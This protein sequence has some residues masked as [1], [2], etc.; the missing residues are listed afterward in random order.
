MNG[1]AARAILAGVL[2]TL[3]FAVVQL[4]RNGV[5]WG[6]LAGVAAAVGMF[7][8]AYWGAERLGDLRQAA[9]EKYWAR[10]EGRHHQFAGVRLRVEEQGQ[11]TWI[12]ADGLT[13]ALGHLDG[14]P[15]ADT[16]AVV[17]ARHAGQWRR[18]EDGTLMLR[19]DAVV[20]R[21]SLMP[22]R[23]DPRVQRLRRYLERDVLFPARR[24][25]G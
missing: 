16:E 10:H 6:L 2:L 12:D 18:A 9:R 3:L 23:D 1:R 15:R 24:R 21:L 22:G 25:R 7:S 11:Q 19:V 13:R 5:S 20:Q 8:I 4:F 17:A 14:R